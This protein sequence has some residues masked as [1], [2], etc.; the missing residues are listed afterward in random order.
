MPV[1]FPVDENKLKSAF[2]AVNNAGLETTP[3]FVIG[4]NADVE[5]AET[6]IQRFTTASFSFQPYLDT[7]K[8]ISG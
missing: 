7:W 4:N 3:F 2:D 1:T 6:L 5:K 8:N